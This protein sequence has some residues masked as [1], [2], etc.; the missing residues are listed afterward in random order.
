MCVCV[1]VVSP[2]RWSGVNAQMRGYCPIWNK[3]ATASSF[4]SCEC[5]LAACLSEPC[6]RVIH[7]HMAEN[8]R[9]H[10]VCTQPVKHNFNIQ[11]VELHWC[12]R[13]CSPTS[14]RRTLYQHSL[15]KK[16]KLTLH[17]SAETAN[18]LYPDGRSAAC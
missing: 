5:C 12:Y 16:K 2:E 4:P 18:C 7:L 17:N 6:R 1:C 8:T 10:S 3:W 11:F 14:I 15:Q 9:A 13:H